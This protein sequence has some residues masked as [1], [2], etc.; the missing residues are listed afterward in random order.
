MP[1]MIKLI[2]TE[3]GKEVPWWINPLLIKLV[4]GHWDNPQTGARV[5]TEYARIIMTDESFVVRESPEQVAALFEAAT[6][7]S[8][9]A[10]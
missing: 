4:V 9:F 7:P 8:V 10:G 3:Y 6:T 5:L 1:R 2:R